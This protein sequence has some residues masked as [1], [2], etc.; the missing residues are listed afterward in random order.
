MRETIYDQKGTRPRES[1]K[2]FFVSQGFYSA[3]E[4]VPHPV[5]DELWIRS[6]GAVQGAT[7]GITMDQVPDLVRALISAYH[8]STGQY[9]RDVE[10]G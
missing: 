9:I 4:G 3:P 1:V 7:V 8:R 5:T 2:V 10:F 6:E